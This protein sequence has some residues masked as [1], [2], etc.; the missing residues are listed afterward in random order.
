MKMASRRDPTISLACS[1]MPATASPSCR[2]CREAS[3]AWL[4]PW[5]LP[6]RWGV[7]WAVARW[8]RPWG[9]ACGRPCLW[10]PDPWAVLWV[11]RWAVWAA[12]P[13]ACRSSSSTCPPAQSSSMVCSTPRR[14]I[15][16]PTRSSSTT[17]M[18]M[19]SRSAGSTAPSLQYGLTRQA[20]KAMFGCASRTSPP[21]PTASVL[22][23]GVGSLASRSSP[24]SQARRLLRPR[25]AG[26]E[27]Q[28]GMLAARQGLVRDA[29]LVS[30]LS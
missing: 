6:W 11:V 24:S 19:S 3:G 4:R 13:E 27:L 8:G 18:R 20:P 5:A 21:Q 26:T 9:E 2:S 29:D 14:S 28:R 16:R 17:S 1:A 23:T 12:M 7:A 30:Q 25:S 10:V 22:L 15:C